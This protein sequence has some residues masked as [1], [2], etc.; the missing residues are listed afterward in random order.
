MTDKPIKWLI[1]S[2]SPY[3]GTGYG[4][5]TALFAEQAHL[6]GMTVKIFGFAGHRGA[7]FQYK[8]IEVF[9]GSLDM[10]GGD[11][12]QA[13]M[14]FHKPDVTMCLFDAWVYT[15]EQLQGVTMWSP[16]DHDPIPSLVAEKLS[17]AKAIWAMSRHGERQIKAAGL[18]CVYVPHGVDVE[19]FYP[20][21]ADERLKEREKRRIKPGQFYAVMVAANKGNNPPRKAF[22]EVLRAWSI[23]IKDHPDAVL[24]IH[25]LFSTDWQGIDLHDCAQFYGIP[26][27]NLSFADPFPLINGFFQNDHLNRLLNAAD[28]HLLPSYGEGFGLPALEAQAAGCPGIVN[29]FTAQSE[30]AGPGYKIPVHDDDLYYT[31]QGS[32]WAR[33]RVSEIVRA[34]EWA[35]ENRENETLRQQSREFALQYDHRLVW[36]QYMKPAIMA[37]VEANEARDNRTAA[38]E[39]LRGKPDHE[40]VWAKT[41]L[42]IKGRLH[43]PCMHSTCGTARVIDNISGAIEVENAFDMDGLDIEDD[44]TGGVSKI[45][46]R[47]IQ[48]AYKLD[49]IEFAPG[50]VVLD[51]GAHVGVVSC[52]LAKKHPDITIYAYEPMPANFARL[53]RNLEANN[54]TNVNAFN[55]AVT[56]HGGIETLYGDT[57][58]N[59]GGCSSFGGDEWTFTQ[60]ESITLRDIFYR[61][62][63]DKVKLIKV[64]IEGAEY[65]VFNRNCFSELERVQHI[66]GEFHTNS[67]LAA[68]GSTPEALAVSLEMRGCDVHYTTQKMAEFE[69]EAVH[70]EHPEHAAAD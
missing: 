62:Q 49:E 57:T 11:M 10:Y 13:H 40:H 47:E 61:N 50:D 64:D 20:L 63:L 39:A 37:Q 69:L 42:Y 58:E 67:Y 35:Y 23:F 18:E 16:I 46:M 66:R 17:Y 7:V 27:Q 55:F 70:H 38:R 29:D 32:H 1:A 21:S 44:P 53:K 41:G 51:L 14:A 45:V 19:S 52:Y 12:F 33:P 28:V 48:D 24:Y 30:L 26:P 68:L 8:G 43:I 36:Q 9:P 25:T 15:Q 4:T 60:V 54:I 56:A 31:P 2:N 59:S 34:L 22:P 3:N 6:D 65:T 5:Q